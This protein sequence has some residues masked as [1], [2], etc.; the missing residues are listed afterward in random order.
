[1]WCS[2]AGLKPLK[3]GICWQE[4]SLQLWDPFFLMP[5]R[6]L[7][8]ICWYD[9]ARAQQG[10]VLCC[11][12]GEGAGTMIS[13]GRKGRENPTN[14]GLIDSNTQ[15]MG[16]KHEKIVLPWACGKKESILIIQNPPWHPSSSNRSSRHMRSSSNSSSRSSTHTN[17][18]D[19]FISPWGGAWGK[20][21]FMTLRFPSPVCRGSFRIL[22]NVVPSEEWLT[23]FPQRL[24]PF[25]PFNPI[26]SQNKSIWT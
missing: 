17:Y 15:P 7:V 24:V 25:R 8:N 12:T 5:L 6:V 10:D 21:V 23:V 11:G 20:A 19:V 18:S 2:G 13:V 9:Q 14:E 1:M 4:A 22:S 26:L 3:H 16:P